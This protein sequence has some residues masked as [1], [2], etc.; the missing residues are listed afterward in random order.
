MFFKSSSCK[1]A[2]I[3]PTEALGFIS[4]T[5]AGALEEII[6]FVPSKK[7]PC[8]H[9]KVVSKVP[10]R[11]HA[12]ISA[13][14]LTRFAFAQMPVVVADNPAL[15]EVSRSGITAGCCELFRGQGK[16][17]ILNNCHVAKGKLGMCRKAARLQ[18]CRATIAQFMSRVLSL[19]PRNASWAVTLLS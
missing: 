15:H 6:T 18:G 13:W 10:Q 11:N 5:L 14:T 12:E 8:L 9:G 3:F 4:A 19:E 17:R 16:R 1:N 7:Y 2:T